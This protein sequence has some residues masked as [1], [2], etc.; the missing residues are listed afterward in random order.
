MTSDSSPRHVLL[1]DDDPSLTEP[2]REA[3][4][5]L[6][7]YGVTVAMDGQS[8]LRALFAQRPDCVVVDIRMP[9]IDGYQFI[10]AVRGDPDTAQIPLVVL[11][12]L[13]Q[14]E[15]TLAG[16]LSGA[17]AYLHKPVDLDDLLAA[18]DQAIA[19]TAVQREARLRALAAGDEGN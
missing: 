4:E 15:N 14:E 1:I 7:G 6:A 16:Y 11:S 8:G 5:L 17:D 19:L 10:H 3:L 18:V 2:L 9:G 13:A 12:A